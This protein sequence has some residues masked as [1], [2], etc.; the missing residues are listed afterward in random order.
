MANPKSNR[1][2]QIP[3]NAEGYFRSL[4]TVSDALVLWRLCRRAK[5]RRANACSGPPQ[6]CLLECSALVPELAREFVIR[7]L[8]DKETGYTPEES[9]RDHPKEAEAFFEWQEA[10]RCGGS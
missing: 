7:A 2:V 6:Q 4:R 9:V 1:H 8:N 5:C 10:G 3:R